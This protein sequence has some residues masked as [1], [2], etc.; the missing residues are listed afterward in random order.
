MNFSYEYPHPAVTTDSVVFGFDGKDLHVLLIERGIEP[1]KGSW[2]L[3]GG[4][5]KM[6]ETAEE[7]ARRELFEETNVRDIFL[8]Q[9]HTFSKVGRD[10]RERVI[11]IAFYALVR[12]GSYEV[13]AGDDAAR[14]HW[15]ILD[16]LPP[17]AF[18]HDEIIDAAREA[19]KKRLRLEPI[20]FRLLDEEFSLSDLQRLYEIIN[21]RSYDRRNFQKKMLAS[22]YLQRMD[23]D[24]ECTDECMTIMPET[25]LA[26]VHRSEKRYCVQAEEFQGKKEKSP[27]R[28]PHTFSFLQRLFEESDDKDKDLFNP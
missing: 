27:G 19:V 3:P 26:C 24:T 11:T 9:F 28:K 5:L 23:V 13:I 12:K 2:A 4:F 1:F 16:E 18:D 15:F 8:E 10:P 21:G 20:A 6:D 17:L 14:A 22:G 7:G 25:R